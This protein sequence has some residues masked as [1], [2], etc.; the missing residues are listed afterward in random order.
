MPEYIKREII[1][2]LIN[3]WKR[4]D[5][6]PYVEDYSM[7]WNEALEQIEGDIRDIP[8]DDVM[9]IVHGYWQIIRW[10]KA[11]C[12]SRC[13]IEFDFGNSEESIFCPNC[14]AKMDLRKR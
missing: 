12:C 1:M 10:S 8:A 6:I 9:K 4:N 7:G 2:N 11:S 3:N 13:G 14:G 5:V